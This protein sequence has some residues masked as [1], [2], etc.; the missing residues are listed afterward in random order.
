[1]ACW[2][3]TP[4]APSTT[5]PPTPWPGRCSGCCARASGWCSTS[6]P[7]GGPRTCAS[8]PRSTWGRPGSG[9]PSRGREAV[10]VGTA[11]TTNKKLLD[12]VDEVA[13]LCRPEAVHWC[14]G[15][16]DE[17][18]RLCQQM[19]EAGTFTRLSDAKRPNSYWATS[20]PGDVA[21]V[22][23]RTFICSEKEIDA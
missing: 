21:R 22:E 4:T 2:C 15:S 20:D 17:Y 10:V 7:R 1:M 11:A 8:A 9:A 12:W 18:D 19:V 3:A 16:A 23:D 6:T 13:A 14:D 5:W